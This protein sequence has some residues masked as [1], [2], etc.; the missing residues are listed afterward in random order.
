MQTAA[1][2]T[3]AILRDALPE[4]VELP[5]AAWESRHRLILLVIAGHV[6]ALP[7][8]GFYNGWGPAY[9]LGEAALVAALGAAAAVPTLGKTLRMVLAS[10]ALATCSAI[11]VQFSGGYIEAHFHY[12]IVVA[13][14]ALYQDWIPFIVAI[15]YVALEHGV[16][17][18]VVPH[19]V[20]NHESGMHEPWKWALIHA[21][22]ILGECVALLAFWAG[23]EQARARSDLVL[24]T[25]GDGVVGL[26][27]KGRIT[28]A[29]P[30]AGALFGRWGQDLVGADVRALLPSTADAVSTVARSAGE[31]RLSAADGTERVVEWTHTPTE[32]SWDAIGAVMVMRDI[33]ARRGLEAQLQARTRQQATVAR[34]GQAALESRDLGALLDLAVTDVAATLGIDLC[35]IL[36]VE[37]GGKSLVLRAGV[38]WRAGLVGTGR[39]SAGQESQAGYTL[40]SAEPVVVRDLA[41]ETRFSGPPLLHDHGVV[42]G[43]SV[44][45]PGKELPWGVLGA[46]ARTRRAFTQDDINFLQGVANLLA[47]AI[48]RHAIEDELLAHHQ[49][50]ESMVARRTS[51]LTEANRELEAFSYT[52]SHDLRSP[53]RS[54][55]GFSRILL[56][57]HGKS[58]PEDARA[59]LGM[60]GDG[61]IRMGNLIESILALSRLSRVELRHA[62][63]DLSAMAEGI[64]TE[65]QDKEPGRRVQWAVEAGLAARGDPDLLRLALLNLLQNSWKFTGRMAAAR[66]AVRSE[67]TPQGRAF[68]VEDNG[69]GFDMALAKDLFQPFHRL[70]TPSEFEGT[71]IGLATVQ[72]IVKRHGGSIW[73]SAEPGKG[74][75]FF[76]T[77]AA[78]PADTLGP[79]QSPEMVI[80]SAEPT[81]QAGG[82]T[83]AVA[84]LSQPPSS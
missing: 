1:K 75:R 29:N 17:G 50:L 33:S 53:L 59:M 74:A 61:A 32:R 57:K 84:A 36:Q 35:K 39:V 38:G 6:L 82:A 10:V 27:A 80:V 51:Q 47:T 22:A 54:I 55:D 43:L 49:N 79:A 19:W 23:A 69:A 63:L 60:L 62:P 77:L 64:L 12:F 2:S 83:V 81:A 72:R 46:H 37:P 70:H 8:F 76:F 52:V 44:I 3:W 15:L 28:F 58:L 73:V 67:D 25:A 26:D 48:E 24:D 18:A 71:G 56:T 68:V 21:V 13:L 78:S 30:A 4:G 16:L 7:L 65:L 45:I 41:L 14:V 11:L 40:A 66:I 42:S 20:F 5:E 9:A 31:G 34:L